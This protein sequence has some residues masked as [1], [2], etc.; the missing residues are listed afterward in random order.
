MARW[1]NLD[2]RSRV[3][4][5]GCGSGY[6]SQLIARRFGAAVVATDDDDQTLERLRLRLQEADLGSAIQVQKISS[7]ELP[8]AEGEFNAI[9]LY[10]KLMFPFGVALP[11]LRRHLAPDG[12]LLIGYPVRVGR[13]PSQAAIE[14]WEKKLGEPLSQP[15]ELLQLF[16]RAGFESESIDTADSL[17]LE[18]FY[19]ALEA[20]LQQKPSSE[21]L[22]VELLRAE[23]AHHRARNGSASVAFAM[24]I[25]RRKEPGEKPPPRRRA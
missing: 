9:V 19:E 16:T 7:T 4:E 10:P 2:Q 22:A 23:I 17:P 20:Q 11:A 13:R 15:G 18:P 3:L 21:A 14:F 6:S 12:R 8:F 5:L 25:G 1:A 24:I